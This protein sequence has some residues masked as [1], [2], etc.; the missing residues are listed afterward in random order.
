MRWGHNGDVEEEVGGMWDIGD[1]LGTLRDE[2]GTQWGRGG[3]GGGDVG[4]WGH[5]GDTEGHI[6]DNEGT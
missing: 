4:H 2:L 1:T 5:V 6:G 3:G